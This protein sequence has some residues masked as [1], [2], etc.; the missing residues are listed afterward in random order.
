MIRI[1]DISFT[2]Y[3][4]V[5]YVDKKPRWDVLLKSGPQFVIS[6]KDFVEINDILRYESEE[7]DRLITYGRPS[8]IDY[9]GD[10]EIWGESL[11]RNHVRDDLVQRLSKMHFPLMPIECNQIGTF[12]VVTESKPELEDK[13]EDDEM[14]I[15]GFDMIKTEQSIADMF[16]SMVEKVAEDVKAGANLDTYSKPK[17]YPQRRY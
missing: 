17:S 14:E 4:A 7:V 10:G 2:R 6:E 11:L 13:L 5:S 3:T 15:K 1:S 16:S 12:P 9:T 8:W